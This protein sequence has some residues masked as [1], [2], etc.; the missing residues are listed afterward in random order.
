LA[1]SESQS[2]KKVRIQIRMK[3]FVKN[4]TLEREKSVFLLEF[5]FL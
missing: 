4:Q 3:I 2:E 5:F 1:G